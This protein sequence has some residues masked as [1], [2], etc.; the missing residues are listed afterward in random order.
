[1]DVE[2]IV[3]R[4]LN[5]MNYIYICILYMYIIYIYMYIETGIDIE[6]VLKKGSRQTVGRAPPCVNSCT[7]SGR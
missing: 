1:M 7:V 4:I 3:H 5:H 2:Y 6:R